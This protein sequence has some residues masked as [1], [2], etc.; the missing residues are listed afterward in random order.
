MS[1]PVF[2]MPRSFDAGT[3]TLQ[4]VLTALRLSLVDESVYENLEDVLGPYASIDATR[5]V[6]L[7]SRLQ[8]ALDGVL[9]AIW[10]LHGHRPAYARAVELRHA[11][12]PAHLDEARA[13]L[14]RLALATMDVLD[15]LALN[16]TSELTVSG[17]VPPAV[18]GTVLMPPC[19]Q[20]SAPPPVSV[21]VLGAG[22]EPTRGTVHV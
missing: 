18:P 3:A 17:A 20:P 10:H 7:T 8:R 14:R 13:H 22:P 11:E 2:T 1:A 21:P 12:R 5:A 6:V 4:R 16:N 9:P 15:L 19:T